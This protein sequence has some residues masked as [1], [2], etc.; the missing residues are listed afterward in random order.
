MPRVTPAAYPVTTPKE[1][2]DKLFLRFGIDT[3]E[4]GSWEKLARLE[5]K[6]MRA[7]LGGC[8]MGRV[9][10]GHAQNPPRHDDAHD[11]ILAMLAEGEATAQDVARHLQR[12]IDTA[13]DHVRAMSRAGLIRREMVG[14]VAVYSLAGAA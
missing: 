6:A 1:Y 2:A 8:T 13:R 5:N 12:H 3:D 4:P 9:D 11:L 14:Q 10:H 7:R